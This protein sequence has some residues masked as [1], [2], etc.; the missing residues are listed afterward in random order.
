LT[1]ISKY[2]SIG[3]TI[4]IVANK[5]MKG[6]KYYIVAFLEKILFLYLK[7]AFTWIKSIKMKN[8]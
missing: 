6:K 2:V 1:I 3:Y 7:D 4:E 5:M 8:V